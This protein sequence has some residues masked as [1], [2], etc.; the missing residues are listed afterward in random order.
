L[1]L[2]NDLDQGFTLKNLEGK[3]YIGEFDFETDPLG[4][5]K[6]NPISHV[7]YGYA[8]QLFIM[9]NEGKVVKVV[10]AHDI[11]RAINPLSLEGQVEGGVAMGLGYALT[12]DFPLKNGIPQVKL[13]TLGLLKAPQMP[14]VEIH[15]IEKIIIMISHLVL[16]ALAKLYAVWLLPRVKMHTIKKMVYLD[17]IIFWIIHTTVS[18][19]SKVIKKETSRN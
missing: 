9:D 6:L 12:E 19:R 8:T 18:Q 10:A 11:G 7:A 3:G 5:P 4:S 17:I 15:L 1:K 16:R 2:K 14:T 13:G